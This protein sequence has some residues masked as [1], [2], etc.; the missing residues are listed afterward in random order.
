[1]QHSLTSVSTGVGTKMTFTD[2]NDLIWLKKGGD[3]HTEPLKVE[4][5]QIEE[6]GVQLRIINT[7][8]LWK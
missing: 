2:K 1:M 3:V 7:I 4:C 5:D 8:L 6:T